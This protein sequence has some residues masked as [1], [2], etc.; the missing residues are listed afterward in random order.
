MKDKNLLMI[1]GPVQVDPAVLHK[2]Q[3]EMFSHRSK[4]YETLQADVCAGLQKILKTN[5]NVFVITGSGTAAIEFMVSN[6]V[7]SGEKVVCCVNGVFGKRLAECVKAFGG[8]TTV[9]ESSSGSGIDLD[10]LKRAVTSGDVKIVAC[11]LNE[12][13]TGVFNQKVEVSRIAKSAGA[14]L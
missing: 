5:G 13:S 14:L 6:L 4:E 3:V 10:G 11:V 7:A 2:M 8:D 1:P 12:T 9:I